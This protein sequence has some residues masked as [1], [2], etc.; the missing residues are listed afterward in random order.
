MIVQAFALLSLTSLASDWPQLAGGPAHDNFRRIEDAI[1]RPYVA[2]RVP[3]AYGQPTLEGDRVYSGG[4][5]LFCIDVHTG[6]VVT[7][8]GRSPD[9]EEWPAHYLAAPALG[10]RYVIARDSY[11]GVTALERDLAAV[12]WSWKPEKRV[13][14]H[15]TGVLA[16]GLYVFALDVELVALEE[17]TGAVRWR[18]GTPGESPVTMV[19]AVHDGKVFAGTEAGEFF[20]VDLAT[21]T[22]LWVHES[23]AIFGTTDPVVAFGLVL[24]GDRGV[25]GSRRREDTGTLT[26]DVFGPRA[27][28]LNAFDP[29]SGELRWGRI[30][31]ATGFSR[32]GIGKESIYAGFGTVLARFDPKTGAIDEDALIRTGRNAFGSPTLVGDTVYF[33]NLDG[34]LYVYDKATGKLQ[35]RFHLDKGQVSDFVHTGDRIYVS[36]SARPLRPGRRPLRERHVPRLRPGVEG[37]SAWVAA[38]PLAQATTG[39]PSPAVRTA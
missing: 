25:S 18:A 39:S 10:G 37:V 29:H 13:A 20:A 26:I 15:Y 33:G 31:G 24:V 11:A 14:T 12:A 17:E 9:W 4:S 2:W 30:F 19:P 6:N 23:D 16:E 3:D 1:V 35:W 36:T 5:A 34:N 32:P 38:D 27:G 22:E 28:A 8:W 7:E 21:G